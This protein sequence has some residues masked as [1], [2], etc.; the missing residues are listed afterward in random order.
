MEFEF[1]SIESK[2]S[3]GSSAIEYAA[4]IITPRKHTSWM[5]GGMNN[6]CNSKPP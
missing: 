2:T 6:T 5:I 4:G 1:D 3:L